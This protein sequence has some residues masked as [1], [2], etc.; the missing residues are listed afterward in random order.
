VES[1]AATRTVRRT[2]RTAVALVVGQ[3]L[4]CA[5]IGWLTFGRS[6]ATAPGR[7]GSTTVDG[8]ALR[9]VDPSSSTAPRNPPRSVPA[10]SGSART[11][12][13]ATRHLPTAPPTVA[14][15]PSSA[16]PAAPA[17]PPEPSTLLASNTTAPVVPPAPPASVEVQAPVLVGA[18]CR[19]AGAFGLT[20]D[21]TAVRCLG[22]HRPRWKIA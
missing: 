22:P 15:A 4:L 12:P 8:L 21:G 2:V 19:P 7:R 11:V 10:A 5:L 17:V 1:V 13:G 16:A 3:A 9:P 20:V 18:R 14:P 6:T